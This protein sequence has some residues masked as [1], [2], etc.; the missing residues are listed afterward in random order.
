MCQTTDRHYRGAFVASLMLQLEMMCGRGAGCLAVRRSSPAWCISGNHPRWKKRNPPKSS[1]S[2]GRGPAGL[3]LIG[4]RPAVPGQREGRK[5]WDGDANE[6]SLVYEHARSTTKTSYD[7]SV[8]TRL[9]KNLCRSSRR[10]A[11]PPR[12]P[13]E[14]M[15]AECWISL[16]EPST[17]GALPVRLFALWRRRWSWRRTEVHGAHLVTAECPVNPRMAIRGF[18][19]GAV[20]RRGALGARASTRARRRGVRGLRA[21]V[22]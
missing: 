14:A 18:L 5:G 15:G 22:A 21:R 13:V 10:Y 20:I 6:P 2:S 4:E 19:A 3:L 9:G 16:R 17:G 1:V 12:W 7:G 8:V 11:P